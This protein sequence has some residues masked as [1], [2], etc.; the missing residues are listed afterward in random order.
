MGRGLRMHMEDHFGTIA[1]T[2][3]RRSFQLTFLLH[4][5]TYAKWNFKGRNQT[6]ASGAGIH[7]GRIEHLILKRVLSQPHRIENFAIRN[8]SY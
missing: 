6:G 1:T 7:M 3:G 4:I 5:P 2:I 8:V